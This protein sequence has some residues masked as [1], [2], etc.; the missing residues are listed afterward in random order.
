MPPSKTSMC[1]DLG[2][3]SPQVKRSSHA[4][5]SNC[6]AHAKLIHPILP[7]LS[8]LC[9]M[10]EASGSG[11]RVIVLSHQCIHPRACLDDCLLWDYE[12]VLQVGCRSQQ[13]PLPVANMA[14]V[15]KCAAGCCCCMADPDA[16]LMC[17]SV[18]SAALRKLASSEECVWIELQ[19]LQRYGGGVVAATLSGHAHVDKY[20]LDE[21]GIHHRPVG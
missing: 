20:H 15:I 1:R 11:E 3:Q 13:R 5:W 2:L 21:T 18:H 17:R 9:G 19:V 14:T 16:A 8:T 6:H 10:Q 7:E 4:P 12:H